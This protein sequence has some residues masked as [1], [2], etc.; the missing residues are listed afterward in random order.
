[1]VSA[2]A[3]KA[4]RVRL[5][6]EERRA[7][8]LDAA[9]RLVLAQGGLPLPLDEVARAARV[10]KALIYAYFPSQYDL[11]NA[12]LARRFEAL[13]AA[14][15]ARAAA[16]PDLTAAALACADLYYDQVAQIGPV[17]HV[18][19]RDP[20]MAGRID[21]AIAAARDRVSRT[22]ARAA[23]RGL[24][25][26]AKEAVAT[27]SLLTTIPEESGRLAFGGELTLERG[28]ELTERLARSALQALAP[29]PA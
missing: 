21:P 17:I 29:H 13:M 24:K 3:Q 20:Y 28:R 16:Q 8:I 27:L 6:P 18:I 1:M 5:P 14:G 4:G 19:L 22:L 26:P 10:S 23:H 12:M 7:L 2:K 15:L 9:E 25:L 11:A